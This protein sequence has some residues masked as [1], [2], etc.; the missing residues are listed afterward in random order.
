MFGIWFFNVLVKGMVKI[1]IDASS[2][3]CSEVASD[4]TPT[5]RG[6]GEKLIADELVELFHGSL[7]SDF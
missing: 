6:I 5:I 4:F 2:T 3:Y 7:C 1:T